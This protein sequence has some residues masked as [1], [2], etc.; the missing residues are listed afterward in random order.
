MRLS[1]SGEPE[2]DFVVMRD[3]RY[4]GALP[5][6]ADVFLIIEVAD[7]SLAYD[8][9]IKFP[10]YAAAGI[11]EAWLVDLKA[12]RLE[13]HTEPQE[14]GYTVM[15][16]AGRG[17]SLPSLRLP[18]LTITVDEI[19]PESHDRDAPTRAAGRTQ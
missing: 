14:G 9:F 11:A 17:G 18:A 10:R 15:V 16:S 5:T 3:R 19:L 2:P 7:S 1:N 12:E 8:R 4:H 13:R 6:V